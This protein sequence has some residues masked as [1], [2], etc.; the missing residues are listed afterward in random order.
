VTKVRIWD[1]P[2]RVFHWALLA[3][4][5]GLFVTGNVGG[6]WMDWHARCGYA[7]L[8]LLLFRVIWGF[9][10][11]RWSRFISFIPSSAA[12]L[13]Y[14]RK[15]VH[16]VGH[17]PLG[18]L[19][20]LAL[21]AVLAMQ[22]GTGLISDDEIAFTGPLVRFV[23]EHTVSVATGYHKHVGKLILLALVGLHVLAILFYGVLKKQQLVKAMISGDQEAPEPA[24]PAA[25]DDAITRM[26]ALVLFLGCCAVVA[27]MTSLGNAAG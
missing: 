9:V 21:L 27:W 5:V 6:E 12:L 11:G 2:T 8:S 16:G 13:A 22:V 10:G 7:V 14:V 19:S 3:A 20:V 23:S 24:P 17:N 15:P 4:V 25:R 26:G 1:L 18:A